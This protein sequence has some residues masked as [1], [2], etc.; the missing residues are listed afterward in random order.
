MRHIV[1]TI[2]E[3][4]LDRLGSV[5]ESLRKEGLI[6]THLYEFGVIIGIADDAVIPK[7]RNRKEIVALN[8]EK[9][10]NIPPPDADVQFFPD[11]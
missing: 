1:I 8:E 7:I 5:A 11:E 2:S 3:I 9:E 10:V 6:V 4:Y